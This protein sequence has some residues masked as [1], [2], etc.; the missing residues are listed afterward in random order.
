MGILAA[1]PL[2]QLQEEEVAGDVDFVALA[3]VESHKSAV[4]VVGDDCGFEGI[5]FNGL[6]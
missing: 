3:E 5:I 1:V 4:G 2:E 6:D